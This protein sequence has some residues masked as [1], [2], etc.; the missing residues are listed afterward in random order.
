MKIP[1]TTRGLMILVAIVGLILGI[2]INF[3]PFLPL[4]VVA[5][6]ILSPQIVVVAICDLPFDAR[7]TAPSAARFARFAERAIILDRRTRITRRP[8]NATSNRASSS[9]RIGHRPP[10]Q[11]SWGSFRKLAPPPKLVPR[12]RQSPSPLSRIPIR[13]YNRCSPASARPA[14]IG[15]VGPSI[16]CECEPPP[17]PDRL[18]RRVT[19]CSAC[20]PCRMA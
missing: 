6:I 4:I 12:N 5:A 18:T 3:A 20:W 13:A 15:I 1:K 8:R 16:E 7:G 9:F 17:C 2:A 14:C 11:P 10:G 19:C